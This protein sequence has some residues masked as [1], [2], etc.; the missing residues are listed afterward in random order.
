MQLQKP[1]VFGAG[2]AAVQ[3]RP[4]GGHAS[5]TIR[6]LFDCLQSDVDKGQREQKYVAIQG[7]FTVDNIPEF[8][9]PGVD[10]D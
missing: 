5:S 10:D 2:G 1:G 7:A 4:G 3:G 8:A 9:P 6:V